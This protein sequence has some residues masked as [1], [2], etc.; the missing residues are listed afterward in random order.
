MI[1]E[2]DI[3]AWE[4]RARQIITALVQRL[5]RTTGAEIDDDM[6]WGP[7]YGRTGTYL[8]DFK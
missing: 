3:P 4:S 8:H 2:E 5:D 6:H 7:K 1:E